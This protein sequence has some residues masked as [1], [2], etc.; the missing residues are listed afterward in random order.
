M[1]CFNQVWFS[2]RRAR[3]RK[4]MG[5]NQLSTSAVNAFLS[6]PTVT[7]TQNGVVSPPTAAAPAQYMLP[8]TASYNLPST[9]NTGRPIHFNDNKLILGQFVKIEKCFKSTYHS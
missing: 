3:W 6:P 4:Q 8:E 5:S 2:N 9:L 7:V 1:F